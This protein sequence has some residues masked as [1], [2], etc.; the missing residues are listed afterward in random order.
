ARA[1]AH[2]DVVHKPDLIAMTWDFDDDAVPVPGRQLIGYLR[3]HP[4]GR[5][6]RVE[7]HQH[8]ANDLQAAFLTTAW[9]TVLGRFA[10]AHSTTPRASTTP[11]PRRR[12][13]TT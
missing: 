2:Y 4:N 9:S 3:I 12:K 10:A 6:S 1:R 11:R 8:A 13:R 5:G 7:V